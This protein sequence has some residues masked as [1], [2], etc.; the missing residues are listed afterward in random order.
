MNAEEKIIEYGKEIGQISDLTVND[1]I[2]S[3]RRLREL[4]SRRWKEYQNEQRS[5]YARGYENGKN[6][7]LKCDYLS[8]E[9]LKAMTITEL[10]ETLS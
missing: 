2:D 1:L 3:H 8:R 4:N 9:D 6:I 10:I 5:G 7:A